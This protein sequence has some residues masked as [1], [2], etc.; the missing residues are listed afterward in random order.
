[1]IEPDRRVYLITTSGRI[2]RSVASVSL[3]SPKALKLASQIVRNPARASAIHAFDLRRNGVPYGHRMLLGKPL[4][5]VDDQGRPTGRRG[6]F[7]MTRLYGEIRPAFYEALGPE[8]FYVID[9]EK[10]EA[11]ARIFNPAPA[12]CRGERARALAPA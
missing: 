11:P 6:C 12:S 4:T 1:M 5:A 3:S 7:M 9:Q 10:S 8:P 2:P